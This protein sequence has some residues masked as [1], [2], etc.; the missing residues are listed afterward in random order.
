[1]SM[2]LSDLFVTG[3]IVALHVSKWRA[4]IKL[5]A[6]DLGIDDST[7]VQKALSLGQH[8]LAPKEAFEAIDA[9]QRSAQFAIDSLS[10]NFAMI[11]GTR[12][13]PDGNMRSLMLQLKMHRAAFYRAVGDFCDVYEATKAAQLPIIQ[14]ALQDA[15]KT[16][17][18]AALAFARIQVEYPPVDEVRR[19]FALKW[20]TYTIR[21]TT[22]RDAIEAAGE[23]GEEVK[24]IVKSMVEQLRGEVQEKL[25]NVLMLITKGGKLKAKSIESANA[26]IDRISALNV[27]GDT[28][29]D[30]QVKAL[31]GVL[32]GIDPDGEKIGSNVVSGLTDIQKALETSMEQAIAEAE[33]NLCALGRRKL[34]IGGE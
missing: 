1:M 19:L 24:S 7:D 16:P 26:T 9:A 15:A 14:R 3:S 10:M 33:Q 32:S 31:R 28:V 21:S 6:Q 5:Q 25:A 30:Q 2:K 8:R 27:F 23:E 22:N 4:R 12:Y 18:A 11:P 20:N 34:D 17:E 13:V 29:L